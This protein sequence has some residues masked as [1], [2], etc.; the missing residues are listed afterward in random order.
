MVQEESK[1][2]TVRRK[3]FRVNKPLTKRYHLRRLNWL[4]D[5]LNSDISDLPKG[6]FTKALYQA[7]DFLYGD[8]VQDKTE[9]K[10]LSVDTD[11]NREGL[12]QIHDELES[13][14][15]AIR[16]ESRITRGD[17]T[18]WVSAAGTVT[19]NLQVAGNEITLVP[20]GTAKRY[21]ARADL[22]FS[23]AHVRLDSGMTVDWGYI[24]NKIESDPKHKFNG[25]DVVG[26]AFFT[27]FYDDDL[28]RTA[29]LS[30]V[31]ILQTIPVQ[32]IKQCK[33]CGKYYLAT[34]KKR[35]PRCRKCLQRH[36]TNNW[37]SKNRK[38]YNAYQRE[39]RIRRDKEKAVEIVLW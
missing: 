3:R 9:I 15:R 10:N 23:G 31:P 35:D 30:L 28:E 21:D 5:F 22:S 16:D 39:L 14:L 18:Q 38:K 33:D 11:L 2:V 1:S 17:N 12:A 8:Q 37:R 36:H 20:N 6:K 24:K 13:N 4:L 25:E 29:L 32:T 34:R 26:Q 27:H 7:L 19:Y